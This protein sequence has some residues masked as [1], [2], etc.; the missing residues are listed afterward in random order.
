[1]FH[2][3]VRYAKEL[4]SSTCQNS[5]THGSDGSDSLT[6]PVPSMQGHTLTTPPGEE[7]IAGQ[8]WHD[9]GF[10][11]TYSFAGHTVH[12]CKRFPVGGGHKESMYQ[13]RIKTK[14]LDR[15]IH[16]SPVV[17]L[18]V[19]IPSRLFTSSKQWSLYTTTLNTH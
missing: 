10:A 19:V 13:S 9:S 18:P 17:K 16:N 11:P 6:L 15:S 3:I 12:G 7:L 4:R 14:Y 2:G 8:G 5:P 1:M